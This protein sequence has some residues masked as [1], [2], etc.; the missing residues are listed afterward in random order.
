[1]FG[2]FPVLP[3]DIRKDD[4]VL[5]LDVIGNELSVWG[6]K[7]GESMPDRP[8]LTAV[9]DFYESGFVRILGGVDKNRTSTTE[10][11]SVWLAQDGHLDDDVIK[12][13]NQKE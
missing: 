6:W 1:M 9:D 5:Q 8:Q 4:G 11:R 13:W 2:G 3:F 7:A 12:R 10:F